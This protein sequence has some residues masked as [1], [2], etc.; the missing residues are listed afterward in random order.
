MRSLEDL[1]GLVTAGLPVITRSGSAPGLVLSFDH[2]T[3]VV[4]GYDGV[5][6]RSEYGHMVP[7]YYEP[8]TLAILNAWMRKLVSEH[9][10]DHVVQ[11]SDDTFDVE[12]EVEEVVSLYLKKISEEP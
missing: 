10:L 11:G 8:A 3:V 4:V 1:P 7:D 6:F 2:N 12:Q 9:W 5:K